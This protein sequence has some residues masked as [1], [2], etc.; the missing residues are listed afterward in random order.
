MVGPRGA[1]QV[2]TTQLDR[3]GF[4]YSHQPRDIAPSWKHNQLFVSTDKGVD[5]FWLGKGGA[6]PYTIPLDGPG[7]ALA[8][9]RSGTRLYAV[10]R[11][12]GIIDVIDPEQYV[13]VYRIRTSSEAIALAVAPDDGTLYVASAE[14]VA[15]IDLGSHALRGATYFAGLVFITVDR[16]KCEAD[17]KHAVRAELEG[18]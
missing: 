2:D 10:A 13:V 9:N 1:V 17:A 3:E 6:V 12:A 7:G 18:A 11:G 8:M 16:A 15:A 4:N 5:L 14:G